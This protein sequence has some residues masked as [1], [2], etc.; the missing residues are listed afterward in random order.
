MP[1]HNPFAKKQAKPPN[2]N[3]IP[4][5]DYPPAPEPL[6]GYTPPAWLV[7]ANA[8]WYKH[9]ERSKRV[10]LVV[11][12]FVLLAIA[13]G[14]GVGYNLTKKKHRPPTDAGPGIWSLAATEC[15]SV[16]FVLYMDQIDGLDYVYLRG[17]LNSGRIWGNT[18]SSQIPAMQFPLP[19]NSTWEPR[20]PS[21]ITAVCIPDASN[22]SSISLR[23]YYIASYYINFYSGIPGY[24]LIENILTFPLPPASLP[25]TPPAFT[26][27]MIHNLTALVWDD[28]APSPADTPLA[29]ITY[30][31][32]TNSSD[33]G[34]KLYFFSPGGTSASNIVEMTWTSSAN[35]T[36]PVQI[37]ENGMLTSGVGTALA[38]TAVP[39]PLAIYVFY[40]NR[41]DNLAEISYVNGTWLPEQLFTQ[42]SFD[43]GTSIIF[44]RSSGGH[45]AA[46]IETVAPLNIRLAVIAANP[47]HRPTYVIANSTGKTGRIDTIGPVNLLPD[48]PDAILYPGLIAASSKKNLY[49]I[50]RDDAGK[51]VDA[52]VF[53]GTIN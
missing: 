17:S 6:P 11:F 25:T 15:E 29:A 24:L 21:S 8:P 37:S 10:W 42:P 31:A 44:D 30:P 13:L 46:T 41:E 33:L 43:K 50:L 9:A 53:T 19:H 35:W 47:S 20:D 52:T 5:E 3:D 27:R 23:F 1:L 51:S 4:L 38:V 32:S 49:Y 12:C 39:S 18:N 14:V 28:M 22:S 36:V 40:L 7:R 48:F 34:I 26:Q 2:F 45:M 16:S